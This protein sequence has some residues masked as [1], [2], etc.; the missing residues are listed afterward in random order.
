MWIHRV[1]VSCV[2]LV[3][4]SACVEQEPTK[5]IAS[6]GPGDGTAAVVGFGTTSGSTVFDAT[7]IRDNSLAA[8]ALVV[9]LV[10]GGARM[11]L[12]ALPSS[13]DD[14]TPGLYLANGQT[15]PPYASLATYACAGPDGGCTA[16]KGYIGTL[17]IDS[18]DSSVTG[19]FVADGPESE[20]ACPDTGCAPRMTGTFCAPLSD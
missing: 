8:N 10:K 6:C 7:A 14:V 9:A 13:G 11:S 1:L 2:C 20:T 18:V 17:T 16:G 12:T 4:M 15:S 19:S 5:T 3:A